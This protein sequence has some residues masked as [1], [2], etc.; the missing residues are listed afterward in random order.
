MAQKFAMNFVNVQR[1]EF[2]RLGVFGDWDNPYLTLE[3]GYEKEIIATFH[4]LLRAK[5]IYRGRK[6]I[7][8][9]WRCETAL[10]EAEVEYE[11]HLSPSIYVKF[12]FNKILSSKDSPL[13]SFTDP[14]AFLVWTTTPWTLVSNVAIALHPDLEYVLFKTEKGEIF[15]FARALMETVLEKTGLKGKV[16]KGLKGRELE[17]AI[18]RHP[19]LARS[20]RLI[21][22]EFVSS[23]EGTGCVHIAPGHGQEDFDVGLKYEPP[24]PVI[25]PVDAKGRFKRLK[26]KDSEMPDS[27]IGKNVF[28]ANE[29]ILKIMRD[30][31]AL[32]CSEETTHSYPHCWRCHKPL[33][34]RATEQWFMGVDRN[35]LRSEALK[36]IKKIKWVP[37]AG[38]KRISSMI[39]LR[40]D[41]CISR[42][43]YWGVPI[44]VLH[45]SSC[46]PLVVIIDEKVMKK[47]EEILGKEGSDAWFLKDASNFVPQGFSCPECSGK[48][49]EKEED[50]LDVWFE[51]GASHLGVLNTRKDLGLPA[52]LYL[53]GSDQHRGWFQSSLLIGMGIVQKSP[54]KG[55]LTHGFVVDGEG[56]KM[57][58]SAGNVI[59]PQ[60]VISKKGA[61]VL[62]LW[63]SA[64]S[65]FDDVRI[66]QEILQRTVETYRKFRNTAKFLLGNIHDFD[67]KKDDV[68]IK[69]MPEI[70]R[71]A[72][73]RVNSVLRD[74]TDAFERFMY[75]EATSCIYK[76]CIMDI[77]SFYLDILKDRLYTFAQDSKL[78]RS[79][80][81][82]L[83]KILDILVR[84]L[85]PL[86]P[87]TAEEIWGCFKG[88]GSVH[89]S[90][91]PEV[92]EALI[93]LELEDRWFRLRG[94][95]EEVLKALEEK[96]IAKVIGGSLEAKIS[97]YIKEDLEYNFLI[98]Y[99]KD[100][101]AIFIVSQVELKKA[102][103]RR[104]GVTKADGKKC[105][106]CWNWSTFVGQD[107]LHPM[108]CKRCREVVVERG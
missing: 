82:V 63:A 25:M 40:P 107:K 73:S 43:R 87:F 104:I 26:E 69:D 2:E 31:K 36:E 51:S 75:H 94:L 102:E 108:L 60:E 21:L 101:P 16:V 33:I 81:T 105:S 17:G 56:K 98:R 80:Q 84:E 45:C 4:K 96:R 37:A 100:L 97:L 67:P 5:F 27:I 66:S 78:R 58:K 39:E 48:R 74:T 62:R 76:F 90:D 92:D 49:F 70:D 1:E 88:E 46:S 42:Q 61:D 41:W 77:S 65:Y 89:L 59:A 99:L 38:E 12:E 93:D 91:W 85:A 83:F 11:M 72:L 23:E 18:A 47:T 54:F 22:A 8:W 44:P 14:V 53:E 57:S 71:W 15:I 52:D 86:I 68:S 19:F 6:P 32:L 3:P 55:V 13:S 50:I 34:T 10:A 79:A 7:R 20:P 95:R 9:C 64:S 24:L 35:D 103:E 28:D 106:R 30:K 29:D